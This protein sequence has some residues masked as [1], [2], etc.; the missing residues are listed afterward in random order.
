MPLFEP[1]L[2]NSV[3]C[4]TF[5]ILAVPA[6]SGRLRNACWDCSQVFRVHH[7]SPCVKSGF[8]NPGMPPTDD[9]QA[10]L[11][12]FGPFQKE[13]YYEDEGSLRGK[14]NNEMLAPK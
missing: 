12:Q 3:S 7:R 4:G 1:P 5:F 2:T 10:V 14:L 11:P 6:Y 13:V 9:P 8:V